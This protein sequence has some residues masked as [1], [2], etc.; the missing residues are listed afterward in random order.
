MYKES[1]KRVLIS[2]E[3]GLTIAPELYY[4]PLEHVCTYKLYQD[5]DLIDIV[6]M[7]CI[8]M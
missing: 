1:I 2:V 5:L 3:E 7:F 8:L 6:Q 4:V